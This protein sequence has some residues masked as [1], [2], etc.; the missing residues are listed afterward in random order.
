MDDILCIGD[1]TIDIFYK[2][3]N[4]P[5]KDGQF[6][7]KLGE[8]YIPDQFHTGL[9]GG[10]ANVAVGCATLGLGTAVLGKIGDNAFKQIIL[11]FFAKKSIS[12]EFLI[13]ES[14]F[15]N[16]SSIFIGTDGGRSIVHFPTPTNPFEI[17]Q[18]YQSHLK[19]FKT[20]YLNNLPGQSIAARCKLLDSIRGSDVRLYLNLGMRD[21]E[22][23]LK[24]TSPLLEKADVLLIN[25]DEY[26]ALIGA[27]K[28]TIKFDTDRSKEI[29]MGDKVLILTD[30]KNGS[31]GYYKGQIVKEPDSGTTPVDTTGAG[32]A[33]AA[34]FIV[35]YQ[36]NQ[37]LKEAMKAG[38]NYAGKI[39]SRIG[40]N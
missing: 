11:Q 4:L 2:G 24:E 8:K 5:E 15:Y 23:G 19:E 16:V 3:K 35:S 37:D 38:T 30:G 1:I 14:D 10:A 26:A 13:S 39:V 12:S 7:F 20:I 9:G 40:A 28:E 18:A 32:D 31:Y 17:S 29:G 34:G 33:Y 21:C 36:E 25:T 6:E 27:K 22:A